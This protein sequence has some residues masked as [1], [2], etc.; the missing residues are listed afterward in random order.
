MDAYPQ[1]LR[2]AR[3]QLRE[4]KPM[5]AHLLERHTVQI[6]IRPNL[7]VLTGPTVTRGAVQEHGTLVPLM[8][9]K[10]G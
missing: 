7:M 6:T 1:L 9:V 3:H 8:C 5:Y 4:D 2:C 10:A